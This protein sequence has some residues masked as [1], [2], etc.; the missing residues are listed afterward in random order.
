MSL[1]PPTTPYMHNAVSDWCVAAAAVAGSEV[2]GWRRLCALVPP[3]LFMQDVLLIPHSVVPKLQH[4]LRRSLRSCHWSVLRSRP[5]LRC[6]GFTQG[7]KTC[8]SGCCGLHFL[9]EPTDCQGTQRQGWRQVRNFELSKFKLLSVQYL[10][11][12]SRTCMRPVY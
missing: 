9:C 3:H 4:R 6:R 7:F 11:Q 5:P 12:I 1:Q 8:F 10:A 2:T